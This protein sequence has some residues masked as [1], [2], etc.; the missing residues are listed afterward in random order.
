[1]P[2]TVF[3]EYFFQAPPF[4]S[5]IKYVDMVATLKFESVAKEKRLTLNNFREKFKKVRYF[6]KIYA[7]NNLNLPNRK[8]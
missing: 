8:I 7:T 1:M 4:V 2:S 3:S 5:K 6:L